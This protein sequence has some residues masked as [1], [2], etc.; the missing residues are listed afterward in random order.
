MKFCSKFRCGRVL[1]EG[2]EGDTCPY[3]NATSY[4]W[5]SYIKE[6]PPEAFE[7]EMKCRKCGSTE[8]L[9]YLEKRDYG[10]F[11][12]GNEYEC[13]SCRD[14]WFAE[15]ARQEA[16]N[17][18]LI[19]NDDDEVLF[20]DGKDDLEKHFEDIEKNYDYVDIESYVEDVIVLKVEKIEGRIEKEMFDRRS[21]IMYDY[22]WYR[23]EEVM[24]PEFSSYGEMSISI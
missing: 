4:S 9:C 11:S 3:C 21:V 12:L 14:A 6:L 19:D 8:E 2:F 23:V 20:F 16:M 22:E 10:S 7:V 15:M 17:Y 5:D 24:K 18:I 13:K 1:P